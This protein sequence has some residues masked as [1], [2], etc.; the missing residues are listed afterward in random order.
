[1]VDQKKKIVLHGGGF[2]HS[3]NEIN[4]MTKYVEW[5]LNVDD[6]NICIYVDDGLHSST[7]P[8]KQNYGWL[9]ESKTIIPEFY[10]WCEKNI[11]LLKT[12]FIKVFTHDK[13][14]TEKSDLFQIVQCDV[15]SVFEDGEIYPKTKLISM[16]TS[17]KNM[18]N[19]HRFRLQILEKYRDK[20]D[21]FGRGYKF[22]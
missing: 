11:D 8:S 14:L 16:V 3:I 10:S 2:R 19:E 15:K 18:C 17:N 21:V 22:Y 12:K 20:C 4:D 13:I 9:R 6:S 7:N 1:M 5:S